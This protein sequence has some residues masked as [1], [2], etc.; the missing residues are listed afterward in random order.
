MELSKLLKNPD[1]RKILRFFHENPNSIDTARG[2]ATWTN[3][4]KKKVTLI[5]KK[6]SDHK[7][8]IAHN[9]SS[10]TGYSYTR[11]KKNMKSIEGLLKG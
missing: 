2:V 1:Y 8:L 3:I 4:D 10:T 9:V 11:N 7:L 5:L 6:L